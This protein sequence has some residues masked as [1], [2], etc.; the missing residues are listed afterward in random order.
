VLVRFSSTATESITMFGDSARQLIK[1]LGASGAIP[2]AISGDDIPAAITR[3]RQA[4]QTRVEQPAAP[5]PTQDT[6]NEEPQVALATRAA[7]LLA[8]LERAAVAKVPVMWEAG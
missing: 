2:G 1:M 5:A 6:D 3:L 4:L 8:L 7:P